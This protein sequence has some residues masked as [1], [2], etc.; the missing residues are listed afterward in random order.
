MTILILLNIINKK[1]NKKQNLIQ[2]TLKCF[3]IITCKLTSM[4][5]FDINS[6]KIS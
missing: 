1:Y 5:G 6:L 4:L 2:M 3:K